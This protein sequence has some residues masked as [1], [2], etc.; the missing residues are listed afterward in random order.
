MALKLCA[1][2]LPYKKSHQALGH[3]PAAPRPPALRLLPCPPRKRHTPVRPTS[4]IPAKSRASPKTPAKSPARKTESVKTPGSG[5]RKR[6]PSPVK[7]PPKKLSPAA[8]DR[9]LR[10]TMEP[11]TD[12][13][14]KVPMEVIEQWKDKE[15]RP[16]LT[17]TFEKL[18]YQADWCL[19][20]S[21]PETLNPIS[22]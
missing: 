6:E 13:T 20:S 8:V 17:A 21:L 2:W 9:R 15:K 5:K 7:E 1:D 10:R 14:Y 4:P 19:K 16:K 11:R 12:G 18:G 22:L 3:R